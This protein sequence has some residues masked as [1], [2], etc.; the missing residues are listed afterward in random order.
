MSPPPGRVAPNIL[1]IIADDHRHDA[2]GAAG[3]P[4]VRTPH[5][6]ALAQRGTR[7][8]MAYH[9][10]GLIAAVCSPTRASL[11]TGRHALAAD[12]TL[13]PSSSPQRT[14]AIPEDC[15]TLPQLFRAVGYDTFI[16]GKWHNDVSSLQRSFSGGRRIFRGG[17]SDHRDVPLHDYSPT[18]DYSQP[19]HE[20]GFSTELFCDAAVDFLAQQRRPFFLY[21]SL[22]SPHDPR[23]PPAA[24]ARLHDPASIPLPGNFMPDHPF[25]NGEIA[26]RDEQLCP[27]PLA[28]DALRAELASY[29]GMIAH[30]DAQIGRV[31]DALKTHGLESNT[32]VVYVS[33]HGLSLGSHGLLGKQNMYEASVRVPLLMAG[34]GVPA[35]R[36][37]DRLTYSLDLYA[38]LAKLAGLTAPRDL[39]SRFVWQEA[40][41]RP[42]IFSMYKDCQRMVRDGR[43]KL[44]RYSV[45]GTERVQLFD[46]REDPDELRDRAGEPECQSRVASMRKLLGAW[47]VRV[48]DRWMV[49]PPESPVLP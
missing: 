38:T 48:E 30:Q 24:F 33:D 49:A 47:Q 18:G 9:M 34:P 28:P 29:Y 42:S 21:L 11:L 27:K 25:D 10:G 40:A 7:F 36:V 35:G 43:W 32:I 37:D 41:G 2:L 16:S 17:M 4:V 26:I 20:D 31:L 3:H 45:N 39:E 13:E 19:H 5:L 8:T 12:A 14:V 6:D 22:T 15:I 46:L 23:T 44:I 1:F